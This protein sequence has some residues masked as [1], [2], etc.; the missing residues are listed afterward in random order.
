[1]QSASKQCYNVAKLQ[2]A[3]LQSCKVA[4]LQSCKV[5]KLQSCNVAK[6]QCCKVTKLQSCKVAKFT[7]AMM[8]SCKVA[9]LQSCN[10]A[11]LQSCKAAKLQRRSLAFKQKIRLHT[12]TQSKW[13]RH[14]LS[15]LSQLKSCKFLLD[16]SKDYFGAPTCN[17]LE[18]Y[19][20]YHT[21]IILISC[22][23]YTDKDKI[24]YHCW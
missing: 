3:K 11:K 2:I 7:V 8:Q 24:T 19:Y 1:M 23:Y 20:Q 22:W 16:G 15:C 4:K 10:V 13:Q 12:H 6:L 14:F 9:K 5:A 18:I 21:N 17:I